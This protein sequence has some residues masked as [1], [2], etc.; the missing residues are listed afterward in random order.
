M[1]VICYDTE[2]IENG[3]TIDLISIGLVAGDGREYYAVNS[4]IDDWPDEELHKRISGHEWLM[5][6]VVPHLPL[7]RPEHPSK[8]EQKWY[9]SL[10]K[11]ST[12]VRPHWVIANEVR[13]FITGPGPEMLPDVELWADYAAYDHV[14]LAQLWGSMTR[15][16]ESIPMWTHDLRQEAERR[17]VTD[18]ELPPLPGATA[19]NALD[20]A[21]EVAYRLRWLSER[22]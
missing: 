5:K 17:D 13:D 8:F 20:D 21:R 22:E 14:A 3:R 2:F 4:G 18:S 9:W 12:L 11:R 19:H 15:L 16:P 10:D 7:A 6:N 1:T